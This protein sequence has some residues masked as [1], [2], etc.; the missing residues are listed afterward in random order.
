MSRLGTRIKNLEDKLRLK[1]NQTNGGVI[2]IPEADRNIINTNR[3]INDYS[4]G[5]GYIFVPQEIND[6]EE[7]QRYAQE[8]ISKN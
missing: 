7:W 8:E 4:G 2:A 5:L 3:L 1:S 6:E